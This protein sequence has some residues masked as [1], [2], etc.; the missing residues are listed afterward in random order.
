MPFRRRK[1]DDIAVHQGGGSIIGPT[2]PPGIRDRGQRDR[3]KTWLV[4]MCYG[5]IGAL[6][7]TMT[8]SFA[9]GDEGAAQVTTCLR[10]R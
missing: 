10:R 2:S 6:G 9:S 4:E 1:D 8:R 3:S 7:C 5:R